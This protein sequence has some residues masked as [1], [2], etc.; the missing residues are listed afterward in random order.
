MELIYSY[1]TK[2]DTRG[3]PIVPVTRLISRGHLYLHAGPTGSILTTMF[4]PKHGRSVTYAVLLFLSLMYPIGALSADEPLRAAVYQGEGLPLGGFAREILEIVARGNGWQLSFEP[5]SGPAALSGLEDGDIDLLLNVPYTDEHR[6]RFLLSENP[7][8]I[9]WT[10]LYSRRDSSL[11]SPESLQGKSIAVPEN[12]PQ[13]KVTPGILREFRL[14]SEL[15]PYPTTA[16]AAQALAQGLV[17][18]A[19]LDRAFSLNG[20]Q[21]YGI[22]RMPY[23]HAPYELRIAA[24]DESM[25]GILA[26][27]DDFLS[28]GRRDGSSPYYA[29]YDRWFPRDRGYHPP[30]HVFWLAIVAAVSI[31]T[32]F[33]GR[34]V[35]RKKEHSRTS[36][37]EAHAQDLEREALEHDA[38]QR[39]LHQLAYYDEITSLPNRLMFSEKLHKAMI[40][41]EGCV[42]VAV[43]DLDRFK[44]FNDTLGHET[45]NALLR[46]TA[47]RIAGALPKDVLLARYGGDEFSV[48]IKDRPP[49]DCAAIAK[50]VVTAMQDPVTELGSELFVTASIGLSHYP[51]EAGNIPEL[52]QQAD[53]AMYRA[54]VEGGGTYCLYDTEVG[55]SIVSRMELETSMRRALV[56]GEM[57]LEYQPQVD[58]E[59]D[60]ILAVEALLRWRH[61]ARGLMETS[62]VI[63]VADETGL[64]IT[65]GEWVME[66]VFA[67]AAQWREQGLDPFRIAVN[68]S[69]KQIQKR[70]FV[71]FVRQL[72]EEYDF[73]PE[74]LELEITERILIDCEQ[75]T[76]TIM[77]ELKE[78]GASLAI[79]NFGTGYSALSYL[80]RFPIDTLKIDRAFVANLHSSD[81]FRAITSAIVA[82]AERLNLRTVAEC[83]EKQEQVAILGEMRCRAA[84]GFYFT[85]PLTQEKLAEW[86]TSRSGLVVQDGIDQDS[87]K[88][89]PSPQSDLPRDTTCP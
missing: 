85:E 50:S 26:T 16:L 20:A 88:R 43:I 46:L 78:I 29:S 33:F 67:Q 74:F 63:R 51:T 76:R 58:L 19:A 62:E 12:T 55:N 8:F 7:L 44:S 15:I 73:P 66:E 14:D 86:V 9:D 83:V 30:A 89:E 47:K 5:A 21:A 82:M 79:D 41:E 13:W 70:D 39:Q 61:P 56:K 80:H 87:F 42:A 68:L 32:F 49:A 22:E 60:R 37:L 72:M 77:N 4:P 38:T 2:S 27:V 28:E 64:V 31:L 24:S 48:L 81:N 10:E 18:A 36:G 52:F 54:K 25:S 3:C 57:W 6:N 40:D 34:L 84:Q 23:S 17:D 45:G 71:Q 11:D 59:S 35:Q 1:K 65:I 75:E 53:I 69:L